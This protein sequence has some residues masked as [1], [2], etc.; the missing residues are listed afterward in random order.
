MKLARITGTV[1]A[2]AKDAALTGQKLLLADVIDGRGKV[3]E[4]ALV[5]IDTSGAGVGDQVLITTGSAARMPSKASGAP[6]DAT[7]I[8]VVDRVTV[9]K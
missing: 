7:I 5:A 2:T 4:P 8:A 6:V 1:E 9:S 3:L